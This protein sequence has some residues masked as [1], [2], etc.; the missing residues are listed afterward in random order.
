MRR[1]VRLRDGVTE[2][3]DAITARHARDVPRAG[4]I[5]LKATAYGARRARRDLEDLVRLLSLVGDV[6][7]VRRELKPSERMRLG[8]ISP[9]KDETY[10]AWSISVDPDDA[11]AAFARLADQ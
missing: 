1:A 3:A 11:R 5:A 6:E 2:L 8:S 9:L 4:A 7:A 10:A